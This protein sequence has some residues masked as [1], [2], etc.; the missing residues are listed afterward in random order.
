MN[1]TDNEMIVLR[2]IVAIHLRLV[3]IDIVRKDNV[4]ALVLQCEPYETDARK[5]FRGTESRL[6]RISAW[7]DGKPVLSF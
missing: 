3:G 4:P 1:V 6:S 5:E 2:P 7:L